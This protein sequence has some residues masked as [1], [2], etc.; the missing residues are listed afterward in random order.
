MTHTLAVTGAKNVTACRELARRCIHLVRIAFHSETLI[1][2]KGPDY[3]REQMQLLKKACDEVFAFVQE[4]LDQGW[5]KKMLT[6][7]K[8]AGQ[9]VVRVCSLHGTLYRF[10]SSTC[11][12]LAAHGPSSGCRSVVHQ[13][14]APYQNQSFL[15]MM[16]YQELRLSQI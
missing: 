10:T 3:L 16:S 13:L 9:I 8:T 12:P 14:M 1:A 2:E 15:Y 11:Q 4:V 7:N 5:P 6:W